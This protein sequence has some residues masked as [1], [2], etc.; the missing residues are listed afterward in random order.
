MRWR[1]EEHGRGGT[2][3]AR[4]AEGQLCREL[5]LP[6]GVEE[7]HRVA[8]DDGRDGGLRAATC[9][10]VCALFGELHVGDGAPELGLV[11]VVAVFAGDGDLVVGG[12]EGEAVVAGPG[13][14]GD[15]LGVLA[16]DRLL[17][18]RELVEEEELTLSPAHGELGAGL[19]PFQPREAA[20]AG[21]QLEPVPVGGV[22]HGDDPGVG[23]RDGKVLRGADCAGRARR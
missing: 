18:A 12:A 5:R 11:H 17:L 7:D 20:E 6:A 3:N 2:G 4:V 21:L 15:G 14:A 19:G 16:H 10:A 1:E 8:A 13:T 23:K 22:V 9:V